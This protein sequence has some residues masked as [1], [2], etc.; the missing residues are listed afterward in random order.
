MSVHTA[1]TDKFTKHVGIFNDKRVA[2]VLQ[3]PEEPDM[4]HVIDTDALPDQFHQSLMSVIDSPEAQAAKWLGDVLHRRPLPDGSN[5]LRTFYERNLIYRV[6]VSKVMLTPYPNRH[7]PLTDVLAQFA[8]PLADVQNG[9]QTRQDREFADIVVQEQ[10]KLDQSLNQDN[11]AD[12]HNQHAQNLQGDQNSNNEA[13]ASNL[14]A[15]AEMLEGEAQRKRAQAAQMV[16]VKKKDKPVK[17][18]AGPFVDS[19]TGKEYKSAAA[20]KGAMTKRVNK[21]KN[22]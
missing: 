19:V 20:L 15:E 3:L 2:V 11:V 9:P 14:I 5:A 21:E 6:P 22:K 1:R 13:I 12:L 7:L 16:E 17:S 18:E 4:V 10:Q 8:D